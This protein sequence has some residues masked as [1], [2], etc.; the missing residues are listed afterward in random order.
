MNFLP[1]YILMRSRNCRC[2][3]RR[4]GDHIYFTQRICENH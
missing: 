3:R 2:R 4:K 1:L